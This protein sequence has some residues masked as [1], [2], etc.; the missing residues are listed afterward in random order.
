MT[1]YF[2]PS[3]TQDVSILSPLVRDTDVEEV[4]AQCGLGI[5][6]ALLMSY[7]S[8]KECNSI[9]KARIQIYIKT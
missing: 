4:K 1:P 3:V 6:N 2:R 5:H 7:E 8:S 9:I